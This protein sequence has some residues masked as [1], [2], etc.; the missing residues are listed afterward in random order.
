MMINTTRRGWDT[1]GDVGCESS[2]GWAGGGGGGYGFGE[3]RDRHS[4]ISERVKNDYK[5]RSVYSQLRRVNERR[6]GD[7]AKAVGVGRAFAGAVRRRSRMHE[8]NST[9]HLWVTMCM[10]REAMLAPFPADPGWRD[11]G[12]KKR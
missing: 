6:H 5:K 12:A 9:A 10:K 8:T 4:R 7:Q 1:R 3:C 11:N 2:A